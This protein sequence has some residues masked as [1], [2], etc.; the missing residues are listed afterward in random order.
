MPA[1]VS[2]MELII[3]FLD[4]CEKHWHSRRALWVAPLGAAVLILLLQ[5]EFLAKTVELRNWIVASVTAIVVLIVWEMTNRVPRVQKKKNGIVIAIVADN[6]EQAVQIRKDFL[7]HLSGL[8]QADEQSTNLRL[9]VVPKFVAERVERDDQAVALLN[10][11]RGVFMLYGTARKRKISGADSHLL[12]LRGVVRHQPITPHIQAQLQGEFVSVLPSSVQFPVDND[13]FAFAFTSDW[14]EIVARYMIGLAAMVS[15]YLPYAETLLL[16]VEARLAGRSLVG[17]MR[18]LRYRVPQRLM[19]LYKLWL[20]ALN[21][22]YFMKRE[23]FVLETAETVVNKV[24]A[25]DPANYN[26]LLFSAI[27]LFVLHRDTSG[28]MTAVLKCRKFP[29]VTWRYSHAFL[30]AY[31]GR[32][33]E[34]RDEYKIACRARSQD[35]TLRIQCEEF[36]QLV[37]H[38]E[39]NKA[40]LHFASALINEYAKSDTEGAKRDYKAFL[41][42]PR[43]AAFPAEVA[44]ARQAIE[45]L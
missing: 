36:I 13:V 17:P 1:F 43:S 22:A 38:E 4:K 6:D 16:Y 33:K 21:Q 9:L 18:K 32:M 8:I 35:R 19:E 25:R 26:A 20:D 37:L 5:T 29:D 34:A 7:A 42:H 40:Q 12:E 44:L 28:A 24:L 30:L 2:N 23:R 14:A 39:P 31:Q 10:K 15:G 11:T 41:D 27:C 3:G 45:R